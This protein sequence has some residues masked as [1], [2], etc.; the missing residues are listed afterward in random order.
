MLVEL[1]DL[2]DKK[3]GMPI[4][5]PHCPVITKGHTMTKPH[6]LSNGHHLESADPHWEQRHINEY[7]TTVSCLY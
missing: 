5:I 1:V 6:G 2:L 4:R 3:H 7:C